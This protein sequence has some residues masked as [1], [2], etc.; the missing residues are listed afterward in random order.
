MWRKNPL[1]VLHH[2]QHPLIMA[3]R[4]D[5]ANV[6]ENT[7]LAFQDAYDLGVDCIE[8]DVHMTKDGEFVFFHD[9]TLN[10]TTNGKGKIA[11]FT[12]EQLKRLD[13]GFKFQENPA[14]DTHAKEIYP[15]RGKGLKIL[16]LDEVLPRFPKV[17]FNMD[18]KSRHPDAPRL[19]AEKLDKLQ[20]TNR[21]IVGSFWQKQIEAF[22]HRSSVITSAGPKGVWKFWRKASKWLKNHNNEV[23]D[24]L[25]Q[26]E[27]FGTKLPFYVLQIPENVSFL[28]IITPE[29]I[30]FA[31]AVGIAV[32][33]WT[34]NTRQDMN[35]LLDWG[36]DGIFTDHPRLLKTIIKERFP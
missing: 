21:V 22:R 36:V 2:E 23:P 14:I 19:L 18:I 11:D 34:I 12:L 20:V 25:N 6:P 7:F 16:S 5:S 8:T 4:G 28:R 32:Q 31:H 17:R 3:H 33:V 29:F 27:I 15:Y 26:L 9:A 35:R 24:E 30:R 13:A 1:P 10:R